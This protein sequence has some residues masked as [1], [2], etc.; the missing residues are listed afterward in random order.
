MILVRVLPWGSWA[1]GDG[2]RL[3]GSWLVKW[4]E[5]WREEAWGIREQ[6]CF[7]SHSNPLG[8]YCYL[9]FTGKEREARR[10]SGTC[11]VVESGINFTEDLASKLIVWTLNLASF[12][13]ALMVL[14]FKPTPSLI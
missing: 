7:Y 4:G 11:P 1:V 10:I 2:Q 9:Q 12:S 13:F 6:C 8:H 5:R 3:N 14:L